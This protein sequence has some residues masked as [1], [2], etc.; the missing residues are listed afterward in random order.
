MTDIVKDLQTSSS[1]PQ[2]YGGCSLKTLQ[3]VVSVKCANEVL[4]DFDFIELIGQGGFGT[5]MKAKNKTTNE[6]VAIKVLPLSQNALNEALVLATLKH[7]NIVEIQ[8]I[9]LGEE[10]LFIVQ[11]LCD[12]SLADRSFSMLEI[13]QITFQ[14]LSALDYIHSQGLVHRDIKPENVMVKSTQTG[15]QVKIIDFGIAAEVSTLASLQ[16]PAGTN[17]YLAPEVINNSYDCKADIWSLGILLLFLINKELPFRSTSQRNIFQEIINFSPSTLNFRDSVDQGFQHLLH[18]FLEKN[19]TR[20][21]S[22]KAALLEP[23][24]KASR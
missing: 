2:L 24:F 6:L 7:Q 1:L 21:L 16:R 5:V 22:A 18:S 19:P 17:Y 13:T 12:C 20:R 14:M 4:N 8:T 3:N 10:Y 11:E 23:I 15:L 9:Y